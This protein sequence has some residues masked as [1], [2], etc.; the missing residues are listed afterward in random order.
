LRAVAT[1]F[2]FNHCYLEFP[3]DI[4]WV[5]ICY[6]QPLGGSFLRVAFEKV[7]IQ[8]S[9]IALTLWW[10]GMGGTSSMAN[11]LTGIFVICKN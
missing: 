8:L 11:Q 2:F 5:L 6:F 3:S 10:F 1:D 7:W 9:A 4:D